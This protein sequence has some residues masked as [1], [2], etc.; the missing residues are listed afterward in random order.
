MCKKNFDGKALSLFPNDDIEEES[1]ISDGTDEVIIKPKKRSRKKK[2]LTKICKT[3]GQDI[4][5]NENIKLLSIYLSNIVNSGLS[6]KFFRSERLGFLNN[7]L[8]KTKHIVLFF[9]I[10]DIIFFWTW[11]NF[12]LHDS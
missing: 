12:N 1:I 2:A 11:Y 6:D 4:L 10:I 7:F 8:H 9:K 3:C 5:E